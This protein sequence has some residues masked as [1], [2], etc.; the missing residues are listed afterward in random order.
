MTMGYSKSSLVDTF[1]IGNVS[2]RGKS[3]LHSHVYC[4]ILRIAKLW[5]HPRC[6]TINEWIKKMWYYK[7]NGSLLSHKEE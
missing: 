1:W 6:P 4:S 3:N 5:K 2:E 7:Y